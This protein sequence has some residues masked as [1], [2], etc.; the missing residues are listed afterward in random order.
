MALVLFIYI[1][2]WSGLETRQ[3]SVAD[4][5]HGQHDDYLWHRKTAQARSC[6]TQKQARIVDQ[7]VVCHAC[8]HTHKHNSHNVTTKGEMRCL[9]VTWVLITGLALF[10][11]GV[12]VFSHTSPKFHVHAVPP[13]GLEDTF[14]KGTL[15][16]SCPSVSYKFYYS[17]VSPLTSIQM[18]VEGR[19]T[20]IDLCRPSESAPGSAPMCP[21]NTRGLIH[22]KGIHV[23]VCDA[24]RYS[25]PQ[26]RIVPGGSVGPL[27]IGSLLKHLDE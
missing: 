1:A 2:T 23:P 16:F 25:T 18:V 3:R 11:I 13:E 19:T 26:V 6:T 5:L 22:A 10:V 17:L 24:I 12:I 14:F 7:D 9:V 20:T 15:S 21:G 27:A 4:C 8:M